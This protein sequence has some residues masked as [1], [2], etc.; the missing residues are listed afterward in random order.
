[1]D[2][3]AQY[4]TVSENLT[5]SEPMFND[6]LSPFSTA[7]T[8]YVTQQTVAAKGG[9][10]Q[11]TIPA[12]N[13]T[14]LI[15]LYSITFLLAVVGNILV[16]VTI[17]QNKRMRTVTNVFLF[18]L[19]VSDLCLALLC[20]PFTLVGNV[21]RTFIFPYSL[22]KIILYFQGVSVNIST[23][24]MVAISVER[25]FAI[26]MPLK[27][28]SWQTKRHAYVIIPSIWIAAF[29]IFIPTAKFTQ[30]QESGPY[31]R[32]SEEWPSQNFMKTYL[33]SLLF[34][35]M[36]IPFLVMVLAY[37]LIILE[38]E[39]G[40]K[41]IKRATIKEKEDCGTKMATFKPT[42]LN[43]QQKETKPKDWNTTA[44]C[45]PR[46]TSTNKAKKR[47]VIML[48]VI[49]ALFFICWTPSWVINIWFVHHQASAVA[50]L[51]PI[52]VIFIRLLTYISS[53]TNP[54]VYCFLNKGFR[55]GFLEAFGCCLGRRYRSNPSMRNVNIRSNTANVT[56]QPVTSGYTNVS[57]ES[58]S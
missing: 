39:K 15:I 29:V 16:M 5:T 45:A 30:V 46:N 21:L 42:P 35:L 50:M 55:Q 7:L 47:V 19:S 44:T 31:R 32:C 8:E 56:K 53:C 1:M 17:V 28:R 58:D 12:V 38:L 14:L 2:E 3:Q 57:S 24:T 4:T 36:V 18:S 52:H 22:C 49:V 25:Y 51:N 43:E 41:Q 11:N 54:I 37:G 10:T 40:M 33:T 20:M 13:T 26:C 34:V 9:T 23:W 6:D 48:I 27:S